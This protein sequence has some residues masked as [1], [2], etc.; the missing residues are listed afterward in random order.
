MTIC[1]HC[2]REVCGSLGEHM[3]HD[4]S[5]LVRCYPAKAQHTR[6]LVTG[7]TGSFGHAFVRRVLEHSLFDRVTCLSRDELKQ[8]QMRQEFTDLRL[9]FYLGDV[10]DV[11]RLER[12]FQDVDVVVHAAALKQ[13]DRSGEAIDEFIAT[14]TLGSLNVIAACHRAGV[15]K[16]VFL[17]SDKACASAT[18]YGSTKDLASWAFI[19]AS[20]WGSCRYSVTRYGNIIASRGSVLDQESPQT[21]GLTDDRMSRFW[22]TIDQAVDLVLLAIQR[23]HGGEVFIPKGIKRQ[24]VRDTFE[25]QWPDTYITVTGKRSYEKITEK[26]VAEEERDRCHDCGDVYVLT[27]FSWQWDPPPYGLEFPLVP[28]DFTYTSRPE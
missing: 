27:P 9:R 25:E 7:G 23:M 4:C 1:N 15:K 28:G 21:I 18:P 10:R 22:M 13:V 5:N 3:E 26:L 2:G 19:G 24:M 12:A 17:S 14:N 11:D 16:C 8:A 6:V 20:A